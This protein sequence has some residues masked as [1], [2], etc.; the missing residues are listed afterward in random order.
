MYKTIKHSFTL[1][2]H[3]LH[4]AKILSLIAMLLPC[5]CHWVD[6]CNATERKGFRALLAILSFIYAYEYKSIYIRYVKPRAQMPAT[7]I[8]MA[9]LPI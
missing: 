7:K 5:Y 2:K 3:Y 1:C 9:I 4:I 8:A 6:C